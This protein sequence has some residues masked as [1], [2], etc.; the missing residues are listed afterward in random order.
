[1][2][3]LLKR[4]AAVSHRRNVNVH[5]IRSVVTLA[6][7]TSCDDTSVAVAELLSPALPGPL[8]VHFHGE[9]SL[10]ARRWP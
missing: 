10:Q 1:M 9:S 3:Q 5:G 7:E 4:S 2:L 6:I 8:K